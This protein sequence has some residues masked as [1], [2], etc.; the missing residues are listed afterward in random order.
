MGQGAKAGILQFFDTLRVEERGSVG[1]TIVMPGFTESEATAGKL[2]GE[3]GDMILDS[4]RR[5][6][7][8]MCPALYLVP[9]FNYKERVLHCWIKWWWITDAHG[10]VTMWKI[11]CFIWCDHNDFSRVHKFLCVTKLCGDDPQA[12]FGP[13]PMAYAATVAKS[14]VSATLRGY[15]YVITPYFY[16]VLLLWRMIAP[17]IIDIMFYFQ[18]VKSP[19]KPAN[20]QVLEVTG[21]QKYLYTQ[22]AQKAD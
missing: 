10:E 16:T 21:A 22:S 5:D 14:A 6:V 11:Y 12:H 19:A 4:E 20:K 17:E 18:A 3:K 7:S 13:Q 15:R 2:V 9:Y 8:V 1:V